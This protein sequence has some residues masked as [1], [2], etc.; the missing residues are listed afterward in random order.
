MNLLIYNKQEKQNEISVI[1][2]SYP[3]K[4]IFQPKVKEINHHNQEKLMP[5]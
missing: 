2:L 4:Q 5:H 3:I 1:I